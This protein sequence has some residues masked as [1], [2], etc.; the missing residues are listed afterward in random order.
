MKQYLLPPTGTF[1]KVNMHCHTTISDGSFTPEE[2]KA[3]D[4]KTAREWNYYKLG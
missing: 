4:E 2:I 1:Y 3:L